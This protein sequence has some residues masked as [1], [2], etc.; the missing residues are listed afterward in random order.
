VVRCAGFLLLGLSGALAACGPA[1]QPLARTQPNR[2]AELPGPAPRGRSA[3]NAANQN[4]E[5]ERCHTDIAS[6]W[7]ASLHARSQTDAVYA[8][9]FALEPLEFCQGCHAPEAD[10][11]APVPEAAASIGVGCVTCHVVQGELLARSDSLGAKSAPHALSR[12]A[13]L[14]GNA[15][16]S[17]CHEFAFPDR[18]ARSRPELMQAT[19]SEHARSAESSSACANCHMPL[20]EH[21]AAPH[22]SH[23]FTGGHDAELVRSAV[24]VTAERTLDGARVT[25]TP[26]QVGHAFPTGDLFRRVE[27]SAEALGSEWQVVASANRYLARHW[28]RLPSPFGVVLRGVVRDDRPLEAAVVVELELGPSAAQLPINWRVAYQRVEHPRS[29]REQ[30]SRVEGEIEIA[31]GALEKNP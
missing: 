12:D 22:K 25:L 10:P 18:T 27:V 2:R 20:S 4:R 11:K 9:A 13:R 17:G 5:C 1:Q 31:S 29:E 14:D 8:R 6:E 23:A 21:G 26:R 24:S 7:R 15:A 28:Q 30:D 19:V 3:A 16:C